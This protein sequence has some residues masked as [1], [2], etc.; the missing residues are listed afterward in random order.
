MLANAPLAGC[1][2][3]DRFRRF[4]FPFPREG[5]GAP[6]D[7]RGLRGPFE[8]KPALEASPYAP[9]FRD[10]SLGGWWGPEARGPSRA[11]RLPALHRGVQYEGHRTPFRHPASRST[12][13][14]EQTRRGQYGGAFKGDDKFFIRQRFQRAKMIE[15]GDS[16]ISP[17]A[18]IIPPSSPGLDPAS[19]KTLGKA[20]S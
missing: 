1:L 19:M 12:T 4:P 10:P 5:N 18:P 2:A 20:Q 15:S 17:P 6:G 14:S 13:P 3:T 16:E 9:R 8:A 11:L 7:A